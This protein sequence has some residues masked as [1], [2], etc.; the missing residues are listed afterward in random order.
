MKLLESMQHF[1]LGKKE[2]P[3]E[4]ETKN[5][6]VS[7]EQPLGMDG[8]VVI[9]G[10]LVKSAIV[11]SANNSKNDKDLIEIYRTIARIPEVNEA[12]D[13]IVNEMLAENEEGK[14][15]DLNLDDVD[16][17]DTI[18]KKIHDEFDNILHVMQFDDRG[19]EYVKRWYID[20][21][22]AFHK[23][24]DKDKLK[25][26]IRSLRYI[27]PVSIE[28][29]VE[30]EKVRE[31]KVEL[32]KTTKEYFRYTPGNKTNTVSIKGDRNNG[33]SMSYGSNSFWAGSETN[34][35][36][37][38]QILAVSPEAIAYSTSGNFDEDFGTILSYLHPAIKVA[39]NLSILEDS[40]VI[41][42]MTRAPERRIFYVD[43]GNLP[44]VKGEQYVN[45]LMTK[46]KSQLSYDSITGTLKDS[47]RFQSMMEDFWIPRRENGRATEITTLPGGQSLGQ[48][49]DVE[50]FLKKLYST[51]KIPASR[52]NKDQPLIAGIGRSS[53]IT[54]D[55]IRFQKFIDRLRAKFSTVFEDVLGTQLVLKKVMDKAEWEEIRGSVKFR[56]AKDS[57]ASEMKETEMLRERI[58]TLQQ[59]DP[60]IGKFFTKEYVLKSILQVPEDEYEELIKDLDQESDQINQDELEVAQQQSDIEVDKAEQMAE[61]KAKYEQP[62]DQP[63]ETK[64]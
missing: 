55:E 42:R 24:V 14:H 16:L 44:K 46:F 50:Y 4:I 18:K 53:E 59:A 1:F 60:Y 61:I 12:I 39:N 22:I 17:S 35:F 6:E 3:K 63:K 56:W 47:R 34:I 41:Y 15:I 49:D 11:E 27:N 37:N 7:F 20:G 31:G 36:G 48:L 64:K 19:H 43:V 9:A 25:D 21:R 8:E 28:K 62:K 57:Y 33:S 45:D 5:G 52:F 13:E 2:D 23:I 58:M 51:L 29:V 10:G 30:Y 26:G 38:N 32:F 54:R 40:L